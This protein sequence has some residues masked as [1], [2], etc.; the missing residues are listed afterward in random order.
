MTTGQLTIVCLTVFA[1]ALV[2]AYARRQESCERVRC[3]ELAASDRIRRD[4]R[5]E[6]DR[7]AAQLAAG[8]ILTPAAGATLAVHLEGR[9]IQ[10]TLDEAD[11]STLV[12][13][14]ANVVTGSDIQPLGGTQYLTRAFITQVQVL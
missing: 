4:D 11:D 7:I 5:E 12:L 2:V 14:D 6:R 8:E 13:S 10:G 3:A 1:I 9:V